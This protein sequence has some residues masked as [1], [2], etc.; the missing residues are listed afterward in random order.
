M[1]DSG[2]QL[3]LIRAATRRSSCWDGRGPA[4]QVMEQRGH[5]EGLPTVGAEKSKA[6]SLEAG[7][8]NR[9]TSTAT[10][11]L[12]LVFEFHAWRNA[13]PTAASTAQTAPAQPM[14]L[15]ARA[16]AS[17]VFPSCAALNPKITTSIPASN[18]AAERV[19]TSAG[20]GSGGI[21]R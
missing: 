7:R 10:S 11:S 13:N 9:T 3:A 15:I 14:S 4:S 12:S 5:A 20:S 19:A 21:E 16:M 2:L 1:P 6:M 18:M 17:T 8:T